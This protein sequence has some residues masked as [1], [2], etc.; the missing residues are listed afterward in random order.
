M[1]YATAGQQATQPPGQSQARGM[2][3]PPI[4]GIGRGGP[5]GFGRGSD[6][7]DFP[8]LGSHVPSS[9]Y[10]S[11][12]QPAQGS[13][14]PPHLAQQML[15]SQG[16]AQGL[17]PPPPPGL[18]V[19]ASASSNQTNG[20]GEN[21]R[22]EDF[23]ALGAGPDGKDRLAGYLRTPNQQPPPSPP[24]TLPNGAG[25]SHSNSAT[26]STN[27]PH[28]A[29][30]AGAPST[31]DS[32]WARHSPSRQQEPIVRPVQQIMSSPADQWGLKGLLYEIQMSLGK[33]DQQ[34]WLFGDDLAE[35]GMDLSTDEPIYHNLVTPWVEPSQ[36][37]HPPQSDDPFHIPQCYY[38]N[39]QPIASKI[40]NF[41]DE[42]LFY[43]F[44]T[45]IQDVSQ[46][47]AAEE[48]Y[49]RNWRYHTE[50]QVWL[51]SPNIPS[52]ENDPSTS[53]LTAPILVFDPSTFS[54]RQ[55]PDDFMVELSLLEK[56]RSA[57]TIISEEDARK[58]GAGEETNGL[59]GRQALASSFG[60][61]IAAR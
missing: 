12:A 9:T 31:A 61:G 41:V 53:W 43:M 40:Q 34:R 56:T 42:T 10:A 38:V 55:T 15:F 11:Q 49:N 48:L 14:Q 51:T 5:P 33:P 58:G 60:Q 50:L 37:S 13:S 4:G 57:A 47:E 6:S 46:L 39:A 24:V 44:Y 2:G 1:Y 17:A 27:P 23:P 59:P 52:V 36:L 45:G 28:P 25:G 18:G 16:M 20:S 54:R 7:S 22:G 29:S 26:P 30:G 3:F 19:P 32:S 8:A 21:L 35:M